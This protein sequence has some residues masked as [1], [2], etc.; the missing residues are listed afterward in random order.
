MHTKSRILVAD[1]QTTYVSAL[2]E[3]LRAF[4]FDVLIAVEGQQTVELVENEKPD[5]IILGIDMP[6]LD[7]YQAC[8]HIRQVSNAPIILLS[9]MPDD[10]LIVKGLNAGADDFI[11]KFIGIEELLARIRA[12]LRR[13]GASGG[14]IEP[15][16]DQH[17]PPS[18]SN[19]PDPST[20]ATSHTPQ[21][22]YGIWIHLQGRVQGAQRSELL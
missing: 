10:T 2:Q 6:G 19:L 13:S 8:R 22:I 7:G 15:A 18:H 17:S 9:G 21:P 20:G 14:P 12:A 16:T 3:L 5:L 11:S 4:D 1:G